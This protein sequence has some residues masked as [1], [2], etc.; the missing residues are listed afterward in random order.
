MSALRWAT[1]T[2]SAVSF[3]SHFYRA[4]QV[5]C[6][7]THHFKIIRT[8]WDQFY[9][10]PY[11][12]MLFWVSTWRLPANLL[13]PIFQLFTVCHYLAFLQQPQYEADRP[14]TKDTWHMNGKNL[15][16][17]RTTRESRKAKDPSLSSPQER[18]YT[19]WHEARWYHRHLLGMWKALGLVSSTNNS[20]NRVV[21]LQ[22][23]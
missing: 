5:P 3:S 2:D 8:W 22:R 14:S 6:S 9:Y 7:L 11:N 4:H 17:A 10:Y 1:G 15:E 20:Q 12:Q 21:S 19:V 23:N 13:A 18:Y 16:W